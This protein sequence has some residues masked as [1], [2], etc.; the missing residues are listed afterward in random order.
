MNPS[1]SPRAVLATVCAGYFIAGWSMAPVSAILPTITHDLNVPVEGG[2]W[3][4]NAYFL[5]LVGSVLTA[6]RLGDSVGHGRVFG[7]GTLIFA[8]ASVIA[9]LMPGFTALLAARAAQGLGSALILGSTLAIVAQ[10]FPGNSRAMAVGL[11]TMTSGFASLAGVWM[12]TLLAE[13]ASWR[14]AFLIPVP[15]GIA[16]AFIAS[17][18]DLVPRRTEP[19]RVDWL[20]AFTLFGAVGF[21]LT[22]MNHLHDGPETFE[23]GAP[24]HVSMHIV[25]LALF[26]AFVYRQLH[27]RNP[28]VRFSLLKNRQLTGGITA[29]GLAHMSMLATSVL[30]PFLLERG[31]DMAPSD[32][33]RL[34][35]VQ[36]VFMLFSAV[37]GG[38]LYSRRPSFVL[39]LVT[40]GMMATGLLLL[41]QFGTWLPYA[42]MFPISAML[43]AGLG[44]FTSI[45]NTYVIGL[46]P[47]DQRGFVGGL[48]ELTRQFGHAIGVSMSSAFLSSALAA[49]PGVPGY[50]MGFSQAA[51]AMGILLAIGLLGVGAPTRQ[52]HAELSRPVARGVR[53]A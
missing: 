26:S 28:L 21:L 29:N 51:T 27:M 8:A 10:T 39:A 44:A 15:V 7:T 32:T 9:A 16:A 49:M 17:R 50:L 37:L 48:T 36:Q 5:V 53:S 40:M 6:G 11:L 3:V 20:S 19:A 45:N 35:L 31:R 33:G 47:A 46:A 30:L 13:G 41:G 4:M 1:L 12:S 14:L 52:S 43:G 18:Y 42:L 38:W 22:G 34:V 24:Y 25:S 23:A 2:A